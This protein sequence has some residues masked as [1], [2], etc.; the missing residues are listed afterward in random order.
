MLTV[1][2]GT[3]PIMGMSGF[4]MSPM[5]GFRTVMA[6]GPTSRTMAGLGSVTSRGAG[7]R[8]TMVAGSHTA[9]PGHGGPGPCMWATTRSGRLRM[10]RSGDG[11][12]VLG[13]ALAG[14]VGVASAGFRLGLATISIPGGVGTATASG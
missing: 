8:I 2:G 4:R 6:T 12:A 11:V 13:S 1:V 9:T 3:S 14:A 7:H 5:A 10:C